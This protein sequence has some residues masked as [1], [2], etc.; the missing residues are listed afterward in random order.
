M[1]DF[2]KRMTVR[3]AM[4]VGLVLLVVDDLS[5]AM[6]FSAWWDAA[7]GVLTVVAGY[8]G[9]VLKSPKDV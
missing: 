8:F 7:W 1:S 4:I 6:D 9:V 3:I 5:A 2:A